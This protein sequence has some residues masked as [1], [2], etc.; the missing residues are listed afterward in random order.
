MSKL[1]Q[2]LRVVMRTLEHVHGEQQLIDDSQELIDR[3]AYLSRCRLLDTLAESYE[4]EITRIEEAL[5]RVKRGNYGLCAGCHQ[6][7]ASQRLELA[8]EAAF[9]ADCQNFRETFAKN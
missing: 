7:I 1:Q 8:P 3:A 9:C 4:H 6:P 5:E 2:R